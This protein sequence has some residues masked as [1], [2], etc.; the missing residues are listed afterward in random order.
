LNDCSG[1]GSDLPQ[2]RLHSVDGW[3][4]HHLDTK[5]REGSFGSTVLRQALPGAF[6]AMLKL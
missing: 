2:H 3:L 6:D 5:H 4:L 1:D